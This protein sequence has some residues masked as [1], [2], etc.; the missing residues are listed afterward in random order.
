MRIF[1]KKSLT[2]EKNNSLKVNFDNGN[3]KDIDFNQSE[4]F[5][6]NGEDI[7]IQGNVFIHANIYVNKALSITVN[8]NS[9]I[10]MIYAP[11]ATIKFS[12][13]PYLTG[14]IGGE[15]YIQDDIE[16]KIPKDLSFPVKLP[17]D[18]L[19]GSDSYGNLGGISSYEKGYF[20]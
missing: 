12:K 19:K 14:I 1:V 4:I 6:Y 2:F 15:V 7:D 10:G 3:K 17:T 11:E 9:V 8:G 16:V 13:G 5:C 20:K 18:L